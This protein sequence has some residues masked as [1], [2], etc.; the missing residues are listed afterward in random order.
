MCRRLVL[1]LLLSAATVRPQMLPP[2][3]MHLERGRMLQLDGTAAIV[4]PLAQL[5]WQL[6]LQGHA[7]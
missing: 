4:G 1:Q 6:L 5:A 3:H 2:L 7:T